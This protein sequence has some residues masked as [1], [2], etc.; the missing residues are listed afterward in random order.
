LTLLSE[1]HYLSGGLKALYAWKAVHCMREQLQQTPLGSLY[2][3]GMSS[4]YVDAVPYCTYEGD[5]SVLMQS[6]AKEVMKMMRKIHGGKEES[7][8]AQ[9]LNKYGK[10]IRREE[11][12]PQQ[13][14]LKDY[15]QVCEIDVME[16]ILERLI[17]V[18]MN[19]VVYKMGKAVMGEKIPEQ[20]AW[21][22][23]FQ[24]D[25]VKMSKL[26]I[27]VM[28]IKMAIEEYKASLK[29]NEWNE[30]TRLIVKM[31]LSLTALA[32][33]KDYKNE[34][35]VLKIVELK[36]NLE[37][38]F[39]EGE[40]Q[41]LEGLESKFGV[42]ETGLNTWKREIIGYSDFDSLELGEYGVRLN[43]QLKAHSKS[44]NDTLVFA[45]KL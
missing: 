42:M 13:I 31:L 15:K 8:E 24:S 40:K 28:N 21:N 14:V 4:L 45:S 16:E 18:K 43:S 23:M 37:D 7:G 26:F 2:L 32:T 19:E 38:V 5:N 39:A 6:V 12:F 30:E 17:V 20:V 44:I 11:K 22:D 33:V 36:E 34:L 35:I 27:E 25:L 1:L 10:V 41:L 3:L 9:F 29:K